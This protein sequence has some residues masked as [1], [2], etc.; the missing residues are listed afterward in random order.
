M[1][2]LLDGEKLEAILQEARDIAQAQ[3][4][5]PDVYTDNTIDALLKISALAGFIRMRAAEYSIAGESK[6][7]G[8][9]RGYVDGLELVINSLKYKINVNT[10]GRDKLRIL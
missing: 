7:S 5:K 1:V 6:K 2:T 9:L 3:L 8:R 4:E 10:K